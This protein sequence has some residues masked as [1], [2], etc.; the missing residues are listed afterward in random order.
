MK[1]HTHLCIQTASYLLPQLL[2]HLT[3]F[4]MPFLPPVFFSSL[5]SLCIIIRQLV[6]VSLFSLNFAILQLVD[7]LIQIFYDLSMPFQLLWRTFPFLQLV[8]LLL[9]LFTPISISVTIFTTQFTML[10]QKPI[11]SEPLVFPVQPKVLNSN[12]HESAS[13]YNQLHGASYFSLQLLVILLIP[14]H[15]FHVLFYFQQKWLHFN[16]QVQFQLGTLIFSFQFV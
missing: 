3:Y 11:V 8:R 7:N 14:G 5:Y 6:H 4:Q 9:Q 10:F 12:Q 13:T 15:L 2:G 16:V 1:H